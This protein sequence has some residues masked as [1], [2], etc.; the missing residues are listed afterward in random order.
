MTADD[1]A[2]PGEILCS[3]CGQIDEAKVDQYLLDLLGE[4][5]VL[6]RLQRFVRRSLIVWPFILVGGMLTTALFS[7]PTGPG[8]IGDD[9]AFSWSYGFAAV[10]ALGWGFVNRRYLRWSI[11][12]GFAL[13]GFAALRSATVIEV[14]AVFGDV[15]I[16][17]AWNWV[18]YTVWAFM[19]TMMSIAYILIVMEDDRAEA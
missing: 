14:R 8:F 12:L 4:V 5:E 2:P 15:A 10:L 19:G 9:P 6:R 7:A 18:A 17:A 13:A 3:T 1:H 11:G 16:S